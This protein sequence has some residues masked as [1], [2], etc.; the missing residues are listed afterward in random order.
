MLEQ[1]LNFTKKTLEN[2]LGYVRPTL[3]KTL[4]FSE[5]AKNFVFGTQQDASNAYNQAQPTTVQGKELPVR[6]TPRGIVT[7]IGR[8]YS[9]VDPFGAIGSME[10]VAKQGLQKLGNKLVKGTKTYQTISDYTKISEAGDRLAEKLN[11]KELINPLNFKTAEDAIN[12]PEMKARWAEINKSMPKKVAGK[13]NNLYH[14]TSAENLDSIIKNGLTTGN[15]ARFEGV[16]SPNKISFSANESGA[17]YF[18]KDGD[19]MIRTKT[20][21]KPTDL[22]LDLLAG[23]EGT[24]VTGKNIPTEMLEIKQGN[25]WITL[26]E[27]NKAHR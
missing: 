19:V 27:W 17:S 20:S 26:S 23:G 12:S 2:T 21:Y 25:K 9:S 3:E 6:L 10:N 5:S 4:N 15:K 22:E 18:G 13:S 8:K 16:S 11:F 14:T 1:A 24:Y 7:N